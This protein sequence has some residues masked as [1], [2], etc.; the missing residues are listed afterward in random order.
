M[1]SRDSRRRALKSTPAQ[2]D[3]AAAVTE[4]DLDLAGAA[5][6]KVAPPAAGT[7]YDAQP[8]DDEADDAPA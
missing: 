5:W 6:R 4:E 1:A 3:S 7:A 8:V 2:L